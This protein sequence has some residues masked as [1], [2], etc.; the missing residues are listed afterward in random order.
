MTTDTPGTPDPT[1]DPFTDP[2][3]P[4]EAPATA[5]GLTLIDPPGWTRYRVDGDLWHG[6]VDFIAAIPSD[7]TIWK[8]EADHPSNERLRAHFLA[9]ILERTPS[10]RMYEPGI[11]AFLTAADVTQQLKIT[12]EE[13]K[14]L[15][16]SQRI[17]IVRNPAMPPVY[18]QVQ[19]ARDGLLLPGLTPVLKTLKP[20][21]DAWDTARWLGTPTENGHSPATLLD[22]GAADTAL[23]LAREKAEQLNAPRSGS[24]TPWPDSGG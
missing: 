18:P 15:A 23:R 2:S 17:L 5:D 20:V 13:L 24:R 11:G 9:Q 10:L 16:R 14:K 12:D 6:T 19:F 8:T 7:T 3:L 22:L 4:M 21:M 1:P